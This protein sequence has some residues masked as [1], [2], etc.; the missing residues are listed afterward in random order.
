MAELNAALHD[1]RSLYNVGSCFRIGSGAGLS[2]LFLSGYTGAPPQPGIAKV[3]LGAEQEV[4]FEQFEGT[5]DLLARIKGHFVVALEQHPES[6]I[7]GD[8]VPPPDRPVTLMLGGELLGL[9]AELIERADAIV[10][11]P[12]AGKKESLNVATA[13]AVVAY[14]LALKLGTTG[15]CDLRSRGPERPVRAGVLTTGQTSG[16]RPAGRSA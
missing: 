6:V 11:V 1:L 3:A 4:P 12:M 14:D 7:V 9:P 8:L 16:E 15:P 13:F 5:G 2:S 10:E